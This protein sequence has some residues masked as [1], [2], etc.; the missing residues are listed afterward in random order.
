M[1]RRYHYTILL[2]SGDSIYG[3][4]GPRLAGML[5]RWSRSREPCLEFN[6]TEGHVSILREQVAG[7]L[8]TED[9][10]T[11]PVGFGR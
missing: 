1:V 6:D 5:K 3:N 4:V 2:K 10:P 11:R 7:V 8:V 9:P